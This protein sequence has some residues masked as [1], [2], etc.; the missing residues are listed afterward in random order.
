MNELFSET[1][2]K[3]LGEAWNHDAQIVEPLH[4][5]DFTSKIAYGFLGDEQPKCLL[6]IVSGT[7][8]KASLYHNEE[9]TWD[10]RAEPQNWE[11]WMTSGFGLSK[12]GAAVATRSLQFKQGDYR[13][14]IRNPVLSRPFL[15]HFVLMNQLKTSF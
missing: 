4:K 7:I 2:I 13:Q 12:L 5:A 8:V 1:W 14:M 3:S 10:L 9:V 11:K 15:R 6:D